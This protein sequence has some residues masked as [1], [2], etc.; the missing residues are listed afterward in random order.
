HTT[1]VRAQPPKDP[2]HSVFRIPWNAALPVPKSPC[3]AAEP[4]SMITGIMELPFIVEIRPNRLATGIS[5][6]LKY[7]LARIAGK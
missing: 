5:T 3:R 4:V 2:V 6:N 7:P 1:V